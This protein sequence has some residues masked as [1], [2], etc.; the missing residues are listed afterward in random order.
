[1]RRVGY[2]DLYA[3]WPGMCDWNTPILGSQGREEI[4]PAAEALSCASKTIETYEGV[5][6]FAHATFEE[7][8]NY[9]KGRQ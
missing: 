6:S 4:A 2:V 8:I 7:L 5:D 9:L 1:M 3:H